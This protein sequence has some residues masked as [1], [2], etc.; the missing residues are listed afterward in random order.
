MVTPL[1]AVLP[2]VDLG[3]AKDAACGALIAQAGK[4]GAPVGKAARAG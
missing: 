1:A 3:L 4:Q 2:F